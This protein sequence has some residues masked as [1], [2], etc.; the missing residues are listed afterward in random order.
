MIC[1]LLNLQHG[2]LAL[3]VSVDG[4]GY[5]AEEFNQQLGALFVHLHAHVFAQRRHRMH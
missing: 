1:S 5:P 4:V 2:K 3:A